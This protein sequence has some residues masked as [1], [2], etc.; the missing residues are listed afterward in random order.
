MKG[1]KPTED[2]Q[3]ETIGGQGHED[4][5]PSQPQA[6]DQPQTEQEGERQTDKTI[7]AGTASQGRVK[8][9]V[10]ARVKGH[11]KDW[12]K[13]WAGNLG[14]IWMRGAHGGRQWRVVGGRKATQ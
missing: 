10:D 11:S 2:E 12:P 6:R 13:E 5:G 9:R 3:D 4:I 1:Q 7:G 14:R 8:A